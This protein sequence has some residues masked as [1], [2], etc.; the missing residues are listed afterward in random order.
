MKAR[1]EWIL[2]VF[3][4]CVFSTLVTSFPFWN[5][6]MPYWMW[7]LLKKYF[8]ELYHTCTLNS[9][10]KVFLL[11]FFFVSNKEKRTQTSQAW[12]LHGLKNVL[13]F[14][15]LPFF[16]LFSLFCLVKFLCVSEFSFLVIWVC[17]QSQKLHSYKYDTL[18]SL[19]WIGKEFI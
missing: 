15:I 13:R 11:I 4:F 10:V 9:N 7:S 12:Q 19:V 1:Q 2:F 17:Y 14:K 3:S 18:E 5:T 6:R 8:T 16:T